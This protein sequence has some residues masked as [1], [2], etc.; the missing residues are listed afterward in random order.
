MDEREV[1]LYSFCRNLNN[2][3]PDE[4]DR[5]SVFIYGLMKGLLYFR[6]TS[7]APEEIKF[8]EVKAGC[9]GLERAVE[10]SRISE[11]LPGHTALSEFK[12]EL[13]PVL[14]Q[15][16]TS[17]VDIGESKLLLHLVDRLA[18]RPRSYEDRLRRT[19]IE[20]M[21]RIRAQGFLRGRREALL[22]D[23]TLLETYIGGRP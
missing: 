2:Q 16:F 15:Y 12:S 20:L 19:G 6:S 13:N 4:N 1:R 7:S 8:Q 5:A 23:Y 22:A 17:P 14:E 21:G 18:Q 11:E 10:L 3:I 9:I